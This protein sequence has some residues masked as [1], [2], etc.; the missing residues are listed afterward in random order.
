MSAGTIFIAL[1]SAEFCSQWAN[2]YSAEALSI[3]L[4]KSMLSNT[5][6]DMLKSVT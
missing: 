5:G 1:L 3:I 4:S 6:K 2:T